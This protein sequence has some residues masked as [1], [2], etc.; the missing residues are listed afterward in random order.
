MEPSIHNLTSSS[1][2]LVDLPAGSP[3]QPRKTRATGMVYAFFVFAAGILLI[4]S[5]V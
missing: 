1:N 3:E 5:A 2:P 4:A